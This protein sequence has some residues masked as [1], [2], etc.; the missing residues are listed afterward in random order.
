VTI[1]KDVE[2]VNEF[3]E[4]QKTNSTLAYNLLDCDYV[5]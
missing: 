3:I 4:A 5:A 2:A 1:V